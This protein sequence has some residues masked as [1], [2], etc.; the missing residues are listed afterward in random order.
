MTGLT[1]L[2]GV[3]VAALLLVS[4]MPAPAAAVDAEAVLTKGTWVLGLQLG[5]GAQDNVEDK[6]TISGIS[7]T[8]RLVPAA[9]AVASM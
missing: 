9:P 6:P 5:G 3:A 4:A 2:I 8:L 1:K 7:F